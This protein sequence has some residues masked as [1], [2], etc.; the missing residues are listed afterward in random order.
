MYLHNQ[1]CSNSNLFVT[2]KYKGN[3]TGGTNGRPTK[4]KLATV[5]MTKNCAKTSEVLDLYDFLCI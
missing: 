5:P 1:I 4:N 3:N 2:V